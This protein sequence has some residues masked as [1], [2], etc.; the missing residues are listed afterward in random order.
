[1]ASGEGWLA[2]EDQERGG[3]AVYLEEH[4]SLNLEGRGGFRT[5]AAVPPWG[6]GQQRFCWGWYEVNLKEKT[7]ALGG[8]AFAARLESYV[9][10]VDSGNMDG[11]VS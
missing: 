8:E 2:R 7:R 1:M 9:C 6:P 10:S 5:R 3:G 11:S 4:T